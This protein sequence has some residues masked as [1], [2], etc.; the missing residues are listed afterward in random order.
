MD[1]LLLIV[2][3]F[4]EG[5]IH[6]RTLRSKHSCNKK[7]IICGRKSSACH[8]NTTLRLEAIAIKLIR[9]GVVLPLP[10]PA[11]PACARVHFDP[12]WSALV[13]ESEQERVRKS[14]AKGVAH[15]SKV[16]GRMPRTASCPAPLLDSHSAPY[17]SP[18]P[19]RYLPAAVQ[20]AAGAGAARRAAHPAPPAEHKSVRWASLETEFANGSE[21]MRRRGPGDELF[22]KEYRAF[23]VSEVLHII[24]MAYLTRC[25]LT[26]CRNRFPA[27]K[28]RHMGTKQ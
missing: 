5:Q 20:W 26:Q 27:G 16:L 18:R 22:T 19:T 10:A 11:S 4:T 21:V 2:L 7:E 1:A 17:S 9:C 3:F 8:L 12:A 24:S 25:L 6:L 28:L 13:P 14:P 15:R 23:R